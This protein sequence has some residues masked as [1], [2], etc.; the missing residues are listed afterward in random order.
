M[1]LIDVK[2]LAHCGDIWTFQLRYPRYIHGELMTHRVFSRNACSS[3]A[4]PVDRLIE[5]VRRDPVVPPVV[6][7]NQPGM[8]GTKY[9]DEVTRGVF[10]SLWY[11]SARKACEIA[12]NM[13]ELN[14]HKQHINRIL[15]PYQFMSTIVTATEWDNFFKLRCA[16]DAQPEMQM[17]AYS[18]KKTMEEV[19]DTEVGVFKTTKDEIILTLPYVRP[20]EFEAEDNYGLSYKEWRM[21]S[22]ARCA[23]VSYNNHDGSKADVKKDLELANRLLKAGHMSCFEHPCTLYK[24]HILGAGMH[25]NLGKGWISAR[26]L[27]EKDLL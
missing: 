23:R 14:I 16:P 21:V 25:Y 20:E 18:I 5:Q 9:A 13:R 6:Y 1:A 2:C 24:D 17:L 7:L 8:V 27:L 15:E 3:R 4:I 10:D 22:A 12:E 19:G 26:Y 11:E